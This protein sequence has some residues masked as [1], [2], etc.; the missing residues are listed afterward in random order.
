MKRGYL[1]EYFEG[2]SMKRLSAVEANTARSN[3]HEYN[4][5]KDMLDFL[6][7]PDERLKLEVTFIYLSDEA[8]DPVVESA[9]MTLYDARENHPSRS[10]YRIYFPGTQVSARANEGDLLVIAKARNG[11]FLSIVAA[12][13]STA[14]HQLAWL[15]GVD[16]Q[17]DKFVTRL[18]LDDERD[19]IGL[20]ASTILESVGIVVEEAADSYLEEMIH[21]FGGVFPTSRIFSAYARETEKGVDAV[22]DPDVALMRWM[23]REELL[24][25]SLERYVVGLRLAEGFRVDQIDEFHS[26]SLSVQNRR[27]ARVGLALENHLSVILDAHGLRYAR[28][29]ITEN[30][31][32]PDFLF[33]GQAQ[34]HDPEFDSGRLT[35][36][37]CKSTCKDRWRQ[38]LAEADRIPEKHLLTMEASISAAQT[39]E[40]RGKSLQLVVPQALHATYSADQQSWLFDLRDFIDLA[41]SRQ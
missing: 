15:F 21:R 32:K 6:G 20:A 23:E 14:A 7:R 41:T 29:A 8:A 27:K 38:V 39:G 25:R 12:K 13:G 33:P 3:Q 4:P 16:E 5:T 19:R 9:W 18:N 36:L 37:A 28:T 34:Y 35:M 11:Q 22:A 1:S 10:E 17:H 40:M 26:Y 30:K 31:A 24:F 2:V